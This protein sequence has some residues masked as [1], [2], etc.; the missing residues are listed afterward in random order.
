M[1]KMIL[2]ALVSTFA[3]SGFFNTEAE[4]EKQQKEEAARLCKVFTMKA[5]KYKKSMRNDTYAKKTL[6]NYI[7]KEQKFCNASKS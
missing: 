2:L 6:A 1:K 3:F 5:E 7:A 4:T